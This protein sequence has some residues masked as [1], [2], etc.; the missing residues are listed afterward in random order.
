MSKTKGT[1]FVTSQKEAFTCCV[2]GGTI[3]SHG[4]YF[5]LGC[6]TDCGGK[7]IF[8]DIKDEKPQLNETVLVFEQGYGIKGNY[9]YGYAVA[10]YIKSPYDGRKKVFA[11]EID[12][13]QNQSKPWVYAKTTHWMSLSKPE[14]L[15]LKGVN[16]VPN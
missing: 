8:R 16:I 1:V 11:R 6:H 12:V 3:E 14:K 13:S 7:Q 5:S 4:M 2:C 10:R 9:F 15:E